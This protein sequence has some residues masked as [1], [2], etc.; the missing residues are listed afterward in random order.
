MINQSI[1]Q[2]DPNKITTSEVENADTHLDQL[3]A[4]IAR[5]QQENEVLLAKKADFEKNK[6]KL[7]E[8]EILALQQEIETEAKRIEAKKAELVQTEAQLESLEGIVQTAEE[9]QKLSE[10][11]TSIQAITTEKKNILVKARDWG[12]ANPGKAIAVTAGL[13]LVVRGISRLFKKKKK[14]STESKDNKEKNPRW[15]QLLIGA[16]I[17]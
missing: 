5:L 17:V 12:L 3:K 2:L 15:K 7:K 10:L 4:D 9:K 8:P 13:G 14:E 11:K 16:G 6:D 1:E